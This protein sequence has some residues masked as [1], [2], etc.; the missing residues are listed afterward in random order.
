MKLDKK[1]LTAIA[2]G[3]AIGTTTTSCEGLLEDNVE[4][5]TECTEDCVEGRHIGHDDSGEYNCPAC[6]MG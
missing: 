3:L 2:I 6:G 4:P 5:Q 1:I